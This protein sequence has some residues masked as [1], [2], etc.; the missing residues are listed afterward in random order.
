MSQKRNEQIGSVADGYSQRIIDSA[1]SKGLGPNVQFHDADAHGEKDGR[2]QLVET[3]QL[4]NRK[5]KISVNVKE[6]NGTYA[7]NQ[8][9]RDFSIGSSQPAV[10]IPGGTTV[11]SVHYSKSDNPGNDGESPWAVVFG[12]GTHGP[13]GNGIGAEADISLGDLAKHP[14]TTIADV[15]GYEVQ[16]AETAARLLHEVGL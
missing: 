12:A 16:A 1:A 3:F 7:I 11:E 6:A 10:S 2:G 8:W 5:I 15:Q 14:D 4:G 9:D 13:D